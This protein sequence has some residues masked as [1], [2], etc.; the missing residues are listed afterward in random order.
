MDSRLQNFVYVSAHWRLSAQYEFA[1]EWKQWM[2]NAKVLNRWCL[3]CFI[4]FK[5]ASEIKI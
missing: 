3:Q 1:S 4:K 2:W 5:V